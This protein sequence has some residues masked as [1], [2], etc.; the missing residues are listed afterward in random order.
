MD[1]T[2]GLPKIVGW[3]ETSIVPVREGKVTRLLSP[4]LSVRLHPFAPGLTLGWHETLL[5]SPATNSTHGSEAEHPVAVQTRNI[6]LGFIPFGV[7]VGADR[8]FV[9]SAPEPGESVV[10]FLHFDRQ[11]MTNTIIRKEELP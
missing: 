3:G 2:T 8:T 1:A 11:T 9:V 6:G 5:F 7:I 10:Q 4:G